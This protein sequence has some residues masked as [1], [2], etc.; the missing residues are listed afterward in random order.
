MITRY[1]LLIC[2][3][4][5]SL[6]GVAQEDDMRLRIAAL[7]GY[8]FALGS[9]HAGGDHYL[10]GQ[11]TN[12][13]HGGISFSK[14]IVNGWVAG[15][16]FSFA[17]YGADGADVYNQLRAHYS[18][19]EYYTTVPDG[20]FSL[21]VNHIGISSGKTFRLSPV[22]EVEPYVL[23]ALG[24]IT[25]I[26]EKDVYRKMKNDNYADTVKLTVNTTPFLFY[27]AIGCRV[28]QRVF[29]VLYIEEGISLQAGSANIDLSEDKASI[30]NTHTLAVT[31]YS[32]PV[33][34]FAAE[35]GL[36]F[37]IG[38]FRETT[39]RRRI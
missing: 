24:W 19:P 39:A 27:P 16:E 17:H 5:A 30:F 7:G 36:Q 1:L 22:V 12:G 33:F 14:N 13:A 10:F 28:Y 8:N 32:Q 20:R 31:S 38:R 18:V 35:L 6:K 25:G 15:L 3:A 21:S 29:H 9:F 34:S 4:I 23:L 37:R 11:M 2:F 26:R